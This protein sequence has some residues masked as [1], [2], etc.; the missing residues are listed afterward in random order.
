MREF[1]NKVHAFCTDE[2]NLHKLI[3]LHPLR[4]ILASMC[5]FGIRLDCI[6]STGRFKNSFFK[7]QH[8]VF[9]ILLHYWTL[10]GIIW[11]CQH[12]VKESTL[13]TSVTIWSAMCTVDFLML[14]R[15]DLNEMLL[16]V[17]A[18]TNK[19]SLKN[20][21]KFHKFVNIICASVWLFV[22]LFL[23]AY[24]I[25]NFQTDF[26][27]DPKIYPSYFV[28][29]GSS[30]TEKMFILNVERSVQTFFIQGS[31][32]VTIA[33]YISLCY[34]AKLWFKNHTDRYRYSKFNGNMLNDQK[35]IQGFRKIFE[36]LS[37]NIRSLDGI[38]SLNVA[39]WLIMILVNMCVRILGILNPIELN[40]PVSICIA[41]LVSLR[42][43]LVLV[44]ISLVADSVQKEAIGS[45]T[46]FEC[47]MRKH[48]IILDSHEYHNVG[49][50]FLKYIRTPI[51]FTVWKFMGLNRS[52]LMTCIGMVAT[53]VMFCI[54]LSPTA[55]KQIGV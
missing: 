43:V 54:Q 34:N 40:S 42:A 33:L 23:F 10:S 17:N 39:V 27:T 35:T 50:I 12:P 4:P 13:L 29:L 32:T 52:F 21:K 31:L 41:M 24:L 53:Y 15:K 49:M 46:K 37:Q 47:L 19:L 55:M 18:E 22:F 14:K 38:F 26:T 9:M 30:Y 6:K 25:L 8:A 51:Q 28:L 1:K 20:K 36:N 11:F 45:L 7:V 16:I 5:I 2:D 48:G 3:E 44:G